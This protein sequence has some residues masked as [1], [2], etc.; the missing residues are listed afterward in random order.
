MS[1]VTRPV[2]QLRGFQRVT[3]QPGENRT[4]TFT[5]T[6]RSLQFWNADMR[7]VVEPGEFEVHVGPNS[8]NLQTAVLTVT[9]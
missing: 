3:L 2:L 7:R 8:V 1:S 4:L 5:L 6:P 9:E